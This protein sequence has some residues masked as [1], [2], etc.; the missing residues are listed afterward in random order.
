[1][2]NLEDEQVRLEIWL[3]D[4]CMALEDTDIKVDHVQHY[5]T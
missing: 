2:R 4:S 3:K 5:L 1:M